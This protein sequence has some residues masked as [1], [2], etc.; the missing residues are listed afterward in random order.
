MNNIVTLELTIDTWNMIVRALEYT[1]QKNQMVIANYI[2]S[3][4]E[5]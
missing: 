3:K 5:N 2:R 4:I 1:E